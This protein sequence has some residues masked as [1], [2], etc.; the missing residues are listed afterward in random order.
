MAAVEK[1]LNAVVVFRERENGEQQKEEERKTQRKS[2]EPNIKIN[3]IT[4]MPTH[5]YNETKNLC[6]RR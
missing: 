3:V 5:Q 4:R 6:Q 2:A 1:V